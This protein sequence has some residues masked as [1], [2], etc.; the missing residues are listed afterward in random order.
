MSVDGDVEGRGRMGR[1]PAAPHT[2]GA[3]PQHSPCSC[4]AVAASQRCGAPTCRWMPWAGGPRPCP[5]WRPAARRRSP[6]A[7]QGEPP[8]AVQPRNGSLCAGLGRPAVSARPGRVEGPSQHARH[9]IQQ[10]RAPRLVDGERWGK[11]LEAA[12][13]GARHAGHK[14]EQRALLLLQGAACA[15]PARPRIGIPPRLRPLQRPAPAL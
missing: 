11:V 1:A 10:L 7:P 9:P 5:P 4:A 8:E 15:A 12:Q 2:P 3:R 13:R 14:L 6:P